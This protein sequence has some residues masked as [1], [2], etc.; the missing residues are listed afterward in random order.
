MKTLCMIFGH[1]LLREKDIMG[2]SCSRCGA[3][4]SAVNNFSLYHSGMIFRREIFTKEQRFIIES[5]KEELLDKVT[6][7]ALAMK[8]QQIREA[9]KGG[10][11]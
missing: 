4:F 1:R 5:E 11:R 10:G 8:E 9:R 6:N 2:A 7:I 3:F